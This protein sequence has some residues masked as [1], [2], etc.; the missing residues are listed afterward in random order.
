MN[1]VTY[2]DILNQAAELAGRT[3]DKIALSEATALQGFLAT[4]LR[5]VWNG[6]YQWPE[7]IPDILSVT[8]VNR[9]FSKNEGSV[10]PLNP[11]MG[12]ILGVWTNNPQTTTSYI[13]LR[14][15][16]QDNKVRIEDGGGTVWVEYMLPCPDL[17]LVEAAQLSAYPISTRFRNYLAYVGAGNLCRADG[18]MAQGD[19]LLA[20]AQSEIMIEIRKLVDV[21][22]RAVKNRNI[23]EVAPQQ[24]AGGG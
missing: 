4:G 23:Y 14:F 13:G 8:A 9:T 11:E 21:P 2:S 1:T 18:Q 15:N 19:E 5:E 20:H 22:R 17:M 10:D 16:E 12:D 6:S 7:L 3:R 24:P